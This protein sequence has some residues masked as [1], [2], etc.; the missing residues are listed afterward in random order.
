[1]KLLGGAGVAALNAM[2][3]GP[4]CRDWLQ[5]SD[6]D[7][8]K[9]ICSYENWVR[10]DG[11]DPRICDFGILVRFQAAA[12][13]WLTF[14]NKIPRICDFTP[15]LG[16]GQGLQPKMGVGY[17]LGHSGEKRSYQIAWFTRGCCIECYGIWAR[18]QILASRIRLG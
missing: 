16:V 5:E 2:K 9:W 8:K 15:F 12:P 7:N 13:G 14:W 10:I 6:W 17:F 3:F 1:M 11:F 18:M 4:G